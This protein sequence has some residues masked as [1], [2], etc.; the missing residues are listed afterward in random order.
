MHNGSMTSPTADTKQVVDD[1]AEKG[2]G[3]GLGTRG[4]ESGPQAGEGERGTPDE[5][6]QRSRPHDANSSGEG[7]AGRESL[8]PGREALDSRALAELTA[9]TIAPLP[10]AV[11]YVPGPGSTVDELLAPGATQTFDLTVD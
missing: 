7:E 8:E 4:A 10:G 6:A 2:Q 1:L 11:A 9:P 3:L 5:P